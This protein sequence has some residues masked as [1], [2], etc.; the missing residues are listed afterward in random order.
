MPV[1]PV[2]RIVDW[3]MPISFQV[4]WVASGRVAARL[5]RV[6]ADWPATKR[7]AAA[8][9]LAALIDAIQRDLTAEDETADNGADAAATG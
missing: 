3:F 8:T 4:E 5:G 6:I 1:A 7:Q 2:T 9:T